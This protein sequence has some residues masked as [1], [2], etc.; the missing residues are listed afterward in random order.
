MNSRLTIVA[1]VIA[2]LVVAVQAL[3]HEWGYYETLLIYWCEALVI[4]AYNVLRL[5]VVG[6]ASEQPFGAWV[7][8]WVE[9]STGF[10]IL[11][12]LLGTAFFAVKFGLFALGVG[13]L[14]IGLP[15]LS[16]DSSSGGGRVMEGF[17]AAGPGVASAV[18][19]LVLSHGV[20]FVRNFLARREYARMALFGLVFWPYVRMS[21]VATVLGFGLILVS[22]FHGLAHATAFTIV[23]ALAKLA[24]DIVTHRLE[25]KWIAEQPVRGAA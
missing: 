11:A 5:L 22:A 14:V 2:N 1:L 12:T 15:A 19:E 7:S 20:S 13:L 9:F 23:M 10:R 21:L 18:G 3:R 24:A 17:S 16:G 6:L 8:K 25:H 4:G